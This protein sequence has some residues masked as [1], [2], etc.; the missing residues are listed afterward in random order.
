MNTIITSALQILFLT[1]GLWLFFLNFYGSFD[2]GTN[3]TINKRLL[4]IFSTILISGSVLAI[5]NLQ[6]WKI[7]LAFFLVTAALLNLALMFLGTGLGLLDATATG[8]TPEFG[9]DL[10][11]VYDSNLSFLWGLNLPYVAQFATTILGIII[12]AIGLIMMYYAEE[13]SEYLK[14][15]IELAGGLGGL[16]TFA[17]YILPA[18]L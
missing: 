2:F 4:M 1:I 5:L 11:I 9:N 6:K 7:S 12:V 10:W 15:V 3:A 13:A 16:Y 8:D 14:C 17:Q 18:I